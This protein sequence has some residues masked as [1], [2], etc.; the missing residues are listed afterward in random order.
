M[1]EPQLTT[2][3]DVILHLQAFSI[4]IFF[5]VFYM[6][7]YFEHLHE[8]VRRLMISVPILH[9]RQNL[10]T[11]FGGRV[12]NHSTHKHTCALICTHAHMYM[13]I[14]VHAQACGI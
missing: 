9:E 6:F 4:C 5:V 10:A 14:C 3:H 7:S 13:E 11:A 1:A 12:P 2:F 8:P